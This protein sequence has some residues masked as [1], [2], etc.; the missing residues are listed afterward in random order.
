MIRSM[1][2][3]GEA[4]RESP[5]GR[6]RL[7]V[8]TVNHRYFNTSIKTPHG[9]DKFERDI[10]EALK[11]YLSRGHI[12]ASMTL[13]RASSAEESAP[14]VDIERAK[15]IQAA[16]EHM[17][18]ELGVQVRSICPSWPASVKSSVL[19]SRTVLPASSPRSSNSL[20]KLRH[21]R[22]SRFAKRKGSGSLRTSKVGWPP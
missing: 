22:S 16:L 4:E 3:Y 21:C 12:S 14:K 19:L 15:Q 17:S 6:L 7:E 20:R 13:D 11:R 5:A 2:G 10:T 8:K 9:F 1:T 18:A